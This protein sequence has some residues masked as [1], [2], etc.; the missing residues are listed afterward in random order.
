[1][2]ISLG[3][4]LIEF[5]YHTVQEEELGRSILMTLIANVTEC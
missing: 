1:M 5:F 4:C 2:I 3:N